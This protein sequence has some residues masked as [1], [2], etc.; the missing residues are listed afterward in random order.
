MIEWIESVLGKETVL[1]LSRYHPAY[2]L[3]IESTSV[4][5]LGLLLSIA[6][7]QLFHV[8]AGNIQLNDY[9][10]TRCSGCG[11]TVIKR[12]GYHTKV[13]ALEDDGACKYCGKH[14]ILR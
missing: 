6:R 9:Q 8:Y 12:A 14:E 11:K 5:N 1:H 3:G 13:I 2:K 10:D 4:S 7:K